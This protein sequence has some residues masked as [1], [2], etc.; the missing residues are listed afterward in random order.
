MSCATLHQ[1]LVVCPPH[2][3]KACEWECMCSQKKTNKHDKKVVHGEW[4][5][6][7][8]LPRK[9]SGKLVKSASLPT[10]ASVTVYVVIYNIME[11][12]RW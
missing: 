11:G 5:I 2:T 3:A 1:Q 12:G 7:T 9:E 4:R 8:K 10:N 6:A